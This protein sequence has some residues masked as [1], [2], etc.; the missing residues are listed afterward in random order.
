MNGL[1]VFWA[2]LREWL[3]ARRIERDLT[4]E[5]QQH[6]DLATDDYVRRGMSRDDARAA[7][8]R[9]FGGLDQAREAV[10]DRRGF[11][12]AMTVAQDVRYALRLLR[13]TPGF[14]AA[15]IGT[16]ALGMGAN[17]AIFSLIDGVLLRPLPYPA[18]DRLVSIWEWNP[19][20]AGR[21]GQPTGPPVRS[22]VAPANLVDYKR[23]ARSF[24]VLA[25]FARVT[26]VVTGRGTPERVLAEQITDGY[27]EAL[28]TRP[29]IGRMFAPEDYAE[30]RHVAIISD[31]L[32]RQRFGS[33]PLVVGQTIEIDGFVT[34][35]VGV[36]PPD[37]RS[38]T[39][40]RLG[41]QVKFLQP[42]VMRPDLI[43]NRDDH[44][45]EVV[46]RLKDG[47][48]AAAARQE[49]AGIAAAIGQQHRKGLTTGADLA[50]LGADQARDV[51]T[52][53]LTLGGG[54][55]FVMLIACVNVASLL[56]VR[57]HARRREIA[58]RF[59]MGATR[60]RVMRELLTQSLVL[61]SVGA[62]AALGVG[63]LTRRA[64]LAMAPVSLPHL[65]SVAL[66]GR[67][68]LFTAAL[69]VVTAL[70]FGLLPAWQVSRTQP[71]TRCAPSIDTS[72]ARGHCAAGTR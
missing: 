37:F 70:I 8:R 60:A 72:R 54:A 59:A 42:F 43:D 41:D 57:S 47:V 61:A 48:S 13:K 2:R 26:S 10:R 24:S 51:R 56:I 32:W 64:L 63:A 44:E 11:R 35:V 15:A 68:L 53:L 16:L 50:P 20:R 69:A 66:D 55:A 6:L 17:V 19:P 23:E 28:A 3:G 4:D 1:R 30:G 71:T 46:G 7:A 36:L 27:F 58:V 33:D 29:A 18:A 40:E 67:A 49:M 38:P 22:V 9:D 52:L 62:I 34:E 31:A 5:L 25:G 45:L 14:T 12:A 21:S 39:D 65:T